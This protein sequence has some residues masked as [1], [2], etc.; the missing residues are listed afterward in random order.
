M[1]GAVADGAGEG[2]DFEGS[3][4]GWSLGLVVGFFD[5][6]FEGVVVGL[7]DGFFVGTAVAAGL[8]LGEAAGAALA[9]ASTG[10]S[11]ASSVVTSASDPDTSEIVLVL[12]W[13]LEAAFTTATPA[14]VA[15]TKMP[16]AASAV[17]RTLDLF[18][19][20]PRYGSRG[21]RQALWRLSR[22]KA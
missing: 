3:G 22:G 16:P 12:T 17:A 14:I 20:P 13:L 7:S 1:A 15:A 4:L 8:G 11:T 18:M 21:Q 5:G 9:G 6:F 19:S 10:G 2:C